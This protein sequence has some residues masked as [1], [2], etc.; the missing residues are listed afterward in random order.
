MGICMLNALWQNMI[1]SYREVMHTMEHILTQEHLSAYCIELEEREKAVATLQKYRHALQDFLAF[2]AGEAVAKS[3]VLAYKQTLCR[4]YAASTVNGRLAAVNGLLEFLGWHECRVHPLR[5]QRM[6]YRDPR[7]ELTREEYGRLLQATHKHSRLYLMLESLCATGIRV[8][9]L[10][11]ITVESLH[12][13]HTEVHNKGKS[14]II[15]LPFKLC[16]LLKQYCRRCGR[17]TGNVFVT[18][19]GQPLDRSN[20]WHM[21]KRLADKAGVD[22]RK[23]YPH[24]L[25]HL[26]ARTFYRVEHDLDHL[27]ALLGHSSINTTRIYTRTGMNAY[28]GQIER[29]HLIL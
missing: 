26:F 5:V 20:I 13:G 12:T 7:R 11:F 1:H 21:M 16:A 29:M 4:R 8:S 19:S 28:R 15:L 23:V 27:A 3:L 25:R 9:E 2:T 22:R 10:R 17:R 6:E 14:R 18:R 24:N